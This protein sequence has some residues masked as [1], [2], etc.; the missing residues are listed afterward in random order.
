METLRGHADGFP[1]AIREVL[2]LLRVA[3]GG[4]ESVTCLQYGF[5]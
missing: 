2:E 5:R 3:R 4:H 1:E